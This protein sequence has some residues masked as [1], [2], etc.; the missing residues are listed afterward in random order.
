VVNVPA[1]AVVVLTLT[2]VALEGEGIAGIVTLCTWS[3][4]EYDVA[5]P[6]VPPDVLT[7]A[8]VEEEGEGIEGSVIL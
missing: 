8:G 3:E 1:E 7:S 6:A 4:R 2:G 5:E